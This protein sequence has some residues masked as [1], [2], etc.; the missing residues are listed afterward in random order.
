MSQSSSNVTT[1]ETADKRS[2]RESLAV[3]LEPASLRML[4]LG[5]SAGVPLMLV[6]GTL[7]FWLREAGID[8]ATIGF[9]SW[10]ALTYP[11]KWCW[12]PMVDRL[13]IPR[14][15]AKLGRRRSWL[16]V[17]QLF[18][19]AG[20]IGM[21]LTEPKMSVMAT[22]GCAL[23][24]SF[25][26]ATQDIALDAYRIESGDKDQQSALAAAYQ[27]GYRVGMIWAGAGALAIAAGAEVANPLN[28]DPHAWR[29]AYLAMAAS[30]LVGVI[31]TLTS[32]N[33]S[34]VVMT[35]EQQTNEV[36]QRIFAE[37][38]RLGHLA[39]PFFVMLLGPISAVL[40]YYAFEAKAIS[41][42]CIAALPLLIALCALAPGKHV[43]LKPNSRASRIAVWFQ[44]SFVMPFVDFFTRYRWHAA[45]ILCLIAT[46]RISD[47]VLGVMAYPF[48]VDMGYTKLEV[49]AI[50]K[51]YGVVM[52]LVGAFIGGVISMR[53]GLMKTLT[54][55]AALSAASNVLYA[56]L[57][58][59]GHD[60]SALTLVISVDNLAT[61]IASTAF[62]AYMS[63]LTNISYSA[64]QYA[65]LSS[66][67]L[68]FP[69]WLAGFSGVAVN[70]MGYPQ[71]FIG[72]A[73]L[74]VPVL[75][76]IW[77]ASR[78]LS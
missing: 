45:L 72:T 21:A 52:T 47:I 1:P 68:L 16:L 55:G 77:L 64:T 33:V 60:I 70:H 8:R 50:S 69:K 51:G 12:A 40:A 44:I 7:S 15:T 20:L 9:A 78:R 6:F 53:I 2:W 41:A 19:M 25:W 11:F 30:M 27:T 42:W 29:V 58:T 62:I 13:S 4:A 61:G 23:F 31:A 46:Y 28:Y 71:F 74:G 14:L 49:A 36:A 57:T 59:R 3:Y 65:L 37:G 67:M 32:K 63:S 76:L 34:H 54:L 10:I 75:V 66:M 38:I 39:L 18:I 5:F 26:S 22:I 17:S 24:A 73:L 56:W 43:F 48:Y 35:A